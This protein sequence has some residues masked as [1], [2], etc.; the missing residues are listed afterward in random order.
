MDFKE[1]TK[2]ILVEAAVLL[3]DKTCLMILNMLNTL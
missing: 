1:H 2:A 3:G